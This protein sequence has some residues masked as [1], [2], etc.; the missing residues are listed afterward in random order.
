MKFE[1]DTKKILLICLFV[2][3]IF[4]ILLT[5]ILYFLNWISGT[6]IKGIIFHSTV[7]IILGLIL[8][9][10]LSIKTGINKTFLVILLSLFLPIVFIAI[11]I[12]ITLLFTPAPDRVYNFY[13]IL[14]I[15]PIIIITIIIFCI[16]LNL[17]VK[18]FC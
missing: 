8:G 3:F 4:G 15:S 16:I 7:F 18:R 12:F 10:F 6:F 17:T 2:G 13:G 5:I 9:F 14:I 1:K 11:S